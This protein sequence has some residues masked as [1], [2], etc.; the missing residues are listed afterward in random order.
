MGTVWQAVCFKINFIHA[1]LQAGNQCT[2]NV[3]RDLFDVRYCVSFDVRYCASFDVRYRQRWMSDYIR[4]LISDFIR[5]SI[6]NF[7]SNIDD[8]H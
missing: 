4:C 3:F 1:I 2:W 6:S 7:I 8:M 5:C